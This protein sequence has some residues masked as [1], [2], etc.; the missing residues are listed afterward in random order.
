LAPSFVYFCGVFKKST[1]SWTSSFAYSIPAT[2]L[3]LV[4]I[5]LSTPKT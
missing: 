1:N 4:F 5:F 3:N 2:C